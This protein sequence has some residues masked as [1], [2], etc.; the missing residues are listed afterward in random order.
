M[1]KNRKSTKY[2]M[3]LKQVSAVLGSDTLK[4]YARPDTLP[5]SVDLLFFTLKDE[6]ALVPPE[7]FKQV[8]YYYYQASNKLVIM[9]SAIQKDQYYFSYAPYIKDTSIIQ[10]QFT[11]YDSRMQSDFILFK[12]K[13][14]IKNHQKPCSR[15]LTKN[16]LT[17]WLIFN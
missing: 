17:N 8:P 5:V 12:R 13:V 4:F 6:N 10:K 7:I 14:P 2:R 16:I 1:D 3:P 9:D 15:P 11:F